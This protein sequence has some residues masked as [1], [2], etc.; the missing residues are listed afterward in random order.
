MSDLEIKSRFREHTSK[1]QFFKALYTDGSKSPDG[2]G[3]AAV[4]GREFAE[5]SLPPQSSIYTAE[6]YAILAAVKMTRG[7]NH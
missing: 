3:Y 2:V 4:S 7:M 1:Y 5:G 6:L